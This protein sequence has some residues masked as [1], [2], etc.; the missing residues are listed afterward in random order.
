MTAPGAVTTRPVEKR[1]AATTLAR[2]SA[3][4]VGA[5]LQVFFR[6]GMAVAFI[7]AFPVVMLLI[8]GSVFADRTAGP[9]ELPFI[10]YFLAGMVAT[11]VMLTSFQNLALSI[12]DER[13]QGLL[14]RLRGTPMPPAAYLVGKVATV[15]LVGAV[16]TAL[17]L[18]T[19]VVVFDVDLPTDAGRWATFAWVYLL[20]TAAGSVLG[21]GV[22]ALPRSAQEANAVITPIVIVLQFV[23]GVYFVFTDLPDWMQSVAS[24]FPLRWMTL[25]MR[26]VFLPDSF[27]AAEPG[28]A[29]QHGLTALVLAAWVVVGTVLCLRTFRWTRRDAG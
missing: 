17:T 5:E 22:S 24:A 18:A 20:G 15:L 11:G 23:S 25:G 29:W 13:D 8:F 7:F 12:A 27:A 21:I 19:A 26:S 16:Q 6:D 10:Q 28:G 4:R 1:S 3:S 9:D 14:K 2:A